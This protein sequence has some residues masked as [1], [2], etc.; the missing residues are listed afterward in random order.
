MRSAEHA[1]RGGIPRRASTG[2]AGSPRRAS[3]G[4]A[5]S[6]RCA[7]AGRVRAPSD[8]PDMPSR[9]ASEAGSSSGRSSNDSPGRSRARRREYRRTL[10]LVLMAQELMAERQQSREASV[11]RGVGLRVAPPEE[12]VRLPGGRE[13]IHVRD[14]GL[15]R[16]YEDRRSPSFRGGPV[17]RGRSGASESGRFPAVCSEA[18]PSDDGELSAGLNLWWEGP[19]RLSLQM[20]DDEWCALRLSSAAHVALDPAHPDLLLVR[21]AAEPRYPP[22]VRLVRLFGAYEARYSRVQRG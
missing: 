1:A 9:Q 8:G 10:E 6:P 17:M 11:P 20:C 16:L 3:A 22:G 2:R 19:R 7:S 15:I 21:P 12:P 5:R 13:L 18:T 4:R 14:D